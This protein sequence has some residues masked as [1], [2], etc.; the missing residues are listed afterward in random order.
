MSRYTHRRKSK[1]AAIYVPVAVLLIFF[2]VALGTS[3]FL[4]ILKIEV[5]GISMYSEEDIIIA[6][7]II[8]GDNMLLVNAGDVARKIY[9]ALPYIQEVSIN[10]SLPDKVRINVSETTAMAAIGY[11]EGAVLLDSAGRVLERAEKK[12]DGLIE[13]KGFTPID[14]KVG[15][16]L[17][18]DPSDDTRLRR[19]KDILPA[20]E[21]AGIQDDVSYL[22]VTDV[23]NVNLKY[24]EQFTVIISGSGG[25]LNRLG[26]LADAVVEA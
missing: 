10:F 4:K 3:V 15:N 2:L 23:G 25:A 26:R 14:V 11:L 6:S 9:A 16:A 5:T 21:R 22:D 13:V 17:R 20:I 7:G 12:P 18:A 8:Q 19:L 24:M 1:S